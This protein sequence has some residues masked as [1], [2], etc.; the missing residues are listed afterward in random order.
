MRRAEVY[1][2]LVTKRASGRCE[3]CHYPQE[4]SNGVLDIEHIVPVSV[5]GATDMDNLAL[6]CRHCNNHKAAK[7]TGTDPNT[8]LVER[9]FHPKRDVWNEHFYLNRKTGEIVGLT[10]VG[11]TTVAELAMNHPL[12]LTTRLRLIAFGVL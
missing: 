8:L 2:Y 1:R 5:G 6:A 7:V 11:R 12:V 10:S 3:Y 9:L 4:M